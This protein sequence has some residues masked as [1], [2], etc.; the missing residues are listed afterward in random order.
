MARVQPVTI[1]RGASGLNN[2]V[3]AARIVRTE[4]AVNDLAAAFNVDID[5][6]NRVRR[7]RGFGGQVVATA[8]HSLW[9]DGE[10]CL[11]V[12]G[13]GL[14]MLRENMTTKGLRN[15][16]QGARMDFC[17]V[18]DKVYY[19]NGF[20]KG[21]V[22]GEASYSWV[23]GTY[24]RSTN[25]TLSSPPIG[26]LLCWYGGRMFIAENDIVWAS[27]PYAANF[28]DLGD[29]FYKFDSRIRM[30]SA[31]SDGLWISDD[32]AVWYLAGGRTDALRQSPKLT[33]PALEGSAKLIN[34]DSVGGG[35]LAGQEL[36]A[37]T[38]PEGICIAGPQGYCA[39][40]TQR[41]LVYPTRSRYA[42][43]LYLAD[44]N[45]FITTLDP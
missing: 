9:S 12:S 2:K 21:Y 7:R 33:Y 1:F 6:L 30:L 16:T 31:V 28:F 20:E 10:Y 4:E 40:L 34:G 25:R 42:S 36:I 8:C 17:R 5:D 19:C 41:R 13:N 22:Y 18:D 23:M 35:E 27:E 45:V 44:D 38:T 39:N 11:Y 26:H 32:K 37:F 43:S 29:A 24:P 3:D 14:Y 15:V